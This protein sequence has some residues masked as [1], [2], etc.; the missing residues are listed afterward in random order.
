MQIKDKARIENDKKGERIAEA[1]R[2]CHFG[3]LL[4][5]LKTLEGI[6]PKKSTTHLMNCKAMILCYEHGVL[7]FSSFYIYM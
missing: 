2:M 7:F 5:I 3:N 1:R 4:S 6:K